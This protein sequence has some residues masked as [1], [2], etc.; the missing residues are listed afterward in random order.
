[1]FKA[2]VKIDNSHKFDNFFLD[3]SA[4]CSEQPS[5]IRA[6]VQCIRIQMWWRSVHELQLWKWYSYITGGFAYQYFCRRK[7]NNLLPVIYT[8]CQK[9][10]VHINTATQCVRKEKACWTLSIV[11]NLCK[12][13]WKLDTIYGTQCTLNDD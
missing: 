5:D 12:A 1:M 11:S 13:I 3:T 8:G 7:Q 4:T 10:V 9:S 2:F 6:M